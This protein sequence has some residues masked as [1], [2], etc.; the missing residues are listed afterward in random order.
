[1]K[2]TITAHAAAIT[3]DPELHTFYFRVDDGVGSFRVERIT[4]R[5]A[6]VLARELA[7]RTGLDAM[8]RPIVDAHPDKYDELV[9]VCY[10][11][12]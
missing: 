10:A 12:T 11:D 6:R 3:E 7:N 1:M 8:V 5:T 9:G 4:V 2:V